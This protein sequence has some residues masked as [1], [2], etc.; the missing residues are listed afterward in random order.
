MRA[1]TRRAGARRPTAFLASGSLAVVAGLGVLGGD[2]GP[3]QGPAACVFPDRVAVGPTPAVSAAARAEADRLIALVHPPAG[4]RAVPKDPSGGGP[5]WGQAGTNR[6]ALSRSWR[7]PMPFTEELGWLRSYDPP[8][9]ARHGLTMMNAPGATG[10]AI[11]PGAYDVADRTFFAKRRGHWSSAL[12]D[13]SVSRG[14]GG[15]AYL[16]AVGIVYPL[17][18]HP[19]PDTWTCVPRMRVL[20]DKPCPDATGDGAGTQVPGV[21]NPGQP[22]LDRV[23]VPAG[24]PTG[25]RICFYGNEIRPSAQ[26]V[27]D[28]AAAARIARAAREVH[29]DHDDYT[30]PYSGLG[31]NLPG[32]V[33]VALAYPGRPDVDVMANSASGIGYVGNGHIEAHGSPYGDSGFTCLL[34]RATPGLP[35]V[36]ADSCP[37]PKAAH[38]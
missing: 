35:R 21:K 16:N 1:F 27:L 29:L 10:R 33:I 7:L 2:H 8:A 25:G 34:T 5:V 11:G 37:A 17:D 13:V 23:L 19:W 24:T 32:I 15:T 3:G 38:R 36:V 6:V 4:S 26:R 30:G 12:L 20:V 18:D 22:D 9:F 28:A 14:R 31:N